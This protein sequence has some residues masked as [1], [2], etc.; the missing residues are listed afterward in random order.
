MSAD[1][2]NAIRA[3]GVR[4]HNLK[5]IDVDVPRG[6]YVAL[7]GVSG[8]GKSSLAL[9]T[10]YAEGQRRYV[11]SFSAYARQFLERMDKPDVDRVENIPPAIAIERKNPVKNR[12]STV[13]TATELNDYLRLLWARV[14][15]VFC[16]DCEVEIEPHTPASIA[17]EALALPEG[18]RFMVSFPLEL[19]PKLS[20]AEQVE[21]IREMGFIRLALD[22]S[23]ERSSTAPRAGGAGVEVVDIS[24]EEPVS[25][26]HLTLP[27]N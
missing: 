11:E 17:R 12:R 4:V 5:N 15:H 1:S 25:Y 23:A 3:R 19:S 2:D 16:P 20:A 14:G 6:R 7:T 18:T 21:R 9:D 10:L 26:T 24:G 13:G 8:S 27:T 22:R